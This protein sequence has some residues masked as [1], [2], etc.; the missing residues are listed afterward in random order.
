MMSK[1]SSRMR[2]GAGGCG[3]GGGGGGMVITPFKSPQGQSACSCG[4]GGCESCQAE[5]SFVRPR[6]FPGQ[7]L[8]EDDLE[9][10]TSYMTAK[11]RLRNRFIYGDGVVCGLEVSGDPCGG[12]RVYVSPGYALDCCGNDIVIG[13]EQSVDVTR[14]VADLI[15][16]CIGADCGDPCAPLPKK[17]AEQNEDPGSNGEIKDN[18]NPEDEPGSGE[19][20]TPSEPTPEPPETRDR[21]YCLYVR[22]CEQ[23]SHPVAPYTTDDPRAAQACEFSRV[24]EGYSFELRCAGEDPKRPDFQQA[25]LGCSETLFGTQNTQSGVNLLL[26]R[27]AL[28]GPALQKALPD[29]N[30]LLKDQGNYVALAQAAVDS[31]L[32]TD[33]LLK[34]LFAEL[35]ASLIVLFDR[36][37]PLHASDTTKV[38][39]DLRKRLYDP[40]D[41]NGPRGLAVQIL[42]EAEQQPS[43]PA[44]IRIIVTEIA[45]M[46]KKWAVKKSNPAEYDTGEAR[47]LA[48]GISL[49]VKMSTAYRGAI[50]DFKQKMIAAASMKRSDW[51]SLKDLQAVRIPPVPT[52]QVTE[53]DAAALY[54]AV[55]QLFQALGRYMKDCM[56][57]AMLPPCPPCDD[58]A[59]LLACITV[60]DCEVVEICNLHRRFVRTPATIRYWSGKNIDVPGD[61]SALDCCPTQMPLVTPSQPNPEGPQK[62]PKPEPLTLKMQPS[63]RSQGLNLPDMISRLSQ[64]FALPP[65]VMPFLAGSSSGASARFDPGTLF[66]RPPPA[67]PAVKEPAKPPAA[68]AVKESEEPPAAPTVKE[69][70]KPPAE[71]ERFGEEPPSPARK[72]GREPKGGGGRG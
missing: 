22:Y 43:L 41:P 42:T 21:T 14:M 10:L 8:T 56:C 67:A 52:Q 70:E 64:A 29:K 71:K 19:G 44:F 60:R 66:S 39:E 32:P 50:I 62:D 47:L 7:L 49:N 27:A 25:M 59:V 15:R 30:T 6:F 12:G 9:Q 28:M 13:C 16:K 55:E 40:N 51:Q 69:P 5:S 61:L 24:Q 4:C 17:K 54:S 23:P 68:P 2:S 36:Q 1:T 33:F 45:E 48:R 11:S 35:W 26:L 18:P 46:A 3:C 65:E 53:A 58:P 37:I 31:T 38:L 63:T 57:R 20:E 34:V 72:P